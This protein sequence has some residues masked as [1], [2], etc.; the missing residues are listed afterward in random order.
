MARVH[1]YHRLSVEAKQRLWYAD[2]ARVS[3]RCAR[4][5][6]VVVTVATTAADALARH[7]AAPSRYSVHAQ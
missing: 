4:C 7:M 5:G 3:A 6:V 1:P 2:Q